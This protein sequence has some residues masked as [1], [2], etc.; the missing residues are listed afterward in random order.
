MAIRTTTHVLKNSDIV[1]RPLPSVL[2]AGEPIVNTADGIL[3]F[4][5]VTTSTA[6]WTPAGTGATE[7]TFFEV[8]SNLYDLRLRNRI[9]EYEGASGAGLDGKFLSGTTNGFVLADISSIAG[10]D[11]YVTGGSMSYVGADGTLTLELNETAP[12]VT[13]TGLTDIYTTGSTLIG[14][15][16]Y[17]DTNNTLSAYTLDLSTFISTGDTYVTGFTYAGASN[18]LTIT[19]NQGLGDLVVNITEVSGLTVNGTLTAQTID[20]SSILSGGTDLATIIG[21]GDTYVTGG[22]VTSATDDTQAATIN[23]TYTNDEG[24]SYTLPFENTYITGGTLN[25]TNLELDKNDGVQEVI[26]LSAL[27]DTDTF[28]TGGTVAYNGTAGTL[29]LTDNNGADVTITG[30]TDD[31]TT[32][33]TLNGNTIE[34]DRIGATNAYS[35]DLSS[36]VSDTTI[37]AFTYDNANLFTISDSN[38]S[39]FTARIDTVTGMTNTGNLDLQGELANS[40]GNVVIN[41]NLD[42][43]GTTTSWGD[44]L[45]GQHLTYDLGAEG[46]RWDELW[47]RKVR[48]GT[49]TTTLEDDGS[50]FTMSGTNGDFI[51]IPVS[52]GNTVFH[53]DVLPDGD[54][55]R[56]LGAS[57]TR[58]N[59]VYAGNLEATGLT[60]SNLTAGRV[61]YVGTGGLLTDE[62]GFEYTEGTDTLTVGNVSVTN[63]VT[64]SGDLTVLGSSISAFT[65]ELYVEDNNIILNY[66][67]TGATNVSSINAGLTIQ[68]GDGASNDVSYDIVRMQN[69]TGLT[70]TEVPDLTEYGGTTGYANRGWIT[71]LNDIIIRSTDAT[72]D[73][74][75]G[76]ITGVRVLAEFDCLDGG[77]Y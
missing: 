58:W 55:T 50:N 2:K 65:S 28:I 20:A 75:A 70:A 42:I 59:N 40:T 33:A 17:F 25:G 10:V 69:L 64:I 44:I 23:L 9:T 21:N 35:V 36:I 60:V 15:V 57:G 62:A 7:Q 48:I 24:G 49:T 22:T 1:G 76:S 71:E 37:T 52:S 39:N 45:P 51:F 19:R 27:A 56:D 38:G 73:G 14:S 16:A 77:T 46:Q 13:I 8:G 74:T 31:Y 41:D 66:N 67:P 5:G 43:T 54:L 61:V 11:T 26:D 4:S 30:F 47:V 6:E 12:N 68:D 34:F 29:T 63:D 18:A 3:Y 53:S 32:G 72:D